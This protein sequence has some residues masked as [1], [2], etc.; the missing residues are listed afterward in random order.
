MSN[1]QDAINDINYNYNYPALNKLIKLV[2]SKYTF[3]RDDIIK[4]VNLESW[5]NYIIDFYCINAKQFLRKIKLEKYCG[6]YLVSYA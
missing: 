2:Q 5:S 1:I 3:S 6:K 4:T